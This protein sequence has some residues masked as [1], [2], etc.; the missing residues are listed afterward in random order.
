MWFGEYETGFER[1]LYSPEDRDPFYNLIRF[2]LRN[3]NLS[4]HSRE[5][6]YRVGTLADRV[7][8]EMRR[9]RILPRIFIGKV[10]EVPDALTNSA[11]TDFGNIDENKSRLSGAT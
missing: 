2:T 11:Y 4:V 1:N 9:T 8:Y 10:Y 7:S 3:E 5:T 6:R